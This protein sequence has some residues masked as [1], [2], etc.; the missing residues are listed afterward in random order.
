[1]DSWLPVDPDSDFSL[2]NLPYGC[3]SR[4]GGRR[5]LCVA[6]GDAIVDLSALQRSGL[7]A[8][9]LLSAAPDCFQQVWALRMT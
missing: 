3:Y 2:A 4:G 6:L 9:P 7:L 1:M 8:G 5:A